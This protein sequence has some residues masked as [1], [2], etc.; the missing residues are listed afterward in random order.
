VTLKPFQIEGWITLSDWKRLSEY[1]YI[2]STGFARQP[3]V[4]FVTSA[5]QTALAYYT[6]SDKLTDRRQD[7]WTGCGITLACIG[8]WFP[9]VCL[10]NKLTFALVPSANKRDVSLQNRRNKVIWGRTPWP[11]VRWDCVILECHR[12]KEVCIRLIQ[13]HKIGYNRPRLSIIC[14]QLDA[15]V[16][17]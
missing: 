16:I 11:P 8:L 15:Y 14:F 9:I 4:A 3:S 17:T 13:P 6:G 7:R 2:L 5:C 1:F 12:L 10:R